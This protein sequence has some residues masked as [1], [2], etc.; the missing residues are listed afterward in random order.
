MSNKFAWRTLAAS[1]AAILF[2]H[3]ASPAQAQNATSPALTGQVSSPEE[4]PMEG[5]LVSA[6]RTGAI[7]T[8]TVVTD[9]Q[10]RYRFPADRLEPGRYTL[11]IRAVGYDLDG[12]NTVEI[13]RQ[14][15]AIA[16]LKLRKAS[17]DEVAAQLTNSEWL[18]SMPGT[19]AQKAS[20]RGC[21]HCH[22]YERIARSRHDADA[23][24]GVIDRMAQHPAASFPLMIQ[25]NFRKRIGDGAMTPERESNCRKAGGVLRNI[26]AAST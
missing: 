15:P 9:A 19:A 20:I 7:V 2:V 16:D 6:K 21:N 25:P 12:P 8:T 17:T 18:M 11:R 26:S 14:K 23:F 22:T 5:V 4:G 3:G 10:G 13:A 1:F 24:M